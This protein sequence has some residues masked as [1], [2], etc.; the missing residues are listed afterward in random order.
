MRDDIQALIEGATNPVILLEGTR[1][2][3]A[4]EHSMLANLATRLFHDFPK[5]VFRSG[6]AEGTDAVFA[7]A[8]AALDPS[9]LQ[10][11]LPHA[12]MGRARQAGRANQSFDPIE[13]PW[14]AI[15]AWIPADDD[16]SPRETPGLWDQSTG[17]AWQAPEID[18]GDGRTLVPD[19][20]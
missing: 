9:R 1:H 3:P 17:A 16:E 7:N 4:E 14:Q 13:P 11:V 20:S 18:P 10:L 5:A 19:D 2:L 8:I 15:R 6:N 12:G